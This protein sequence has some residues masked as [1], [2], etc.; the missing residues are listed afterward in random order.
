V[1]A[2]RV[3]EI[4]DRFVD[5]NS[6]V[7]PL[8]IEFVADETAVAAATL[9]YFARRSTHLRPTRPAQR[10][11]ILFQH[12]TRASAR[13]IAG[14][15]AL[16]QHEAT[17]L[18]HDPYSAT[19]AGAHGHLLAQEFCQVLPELQDMVSART[20]DI[21]DLVCDALRRS[22]RQF[23]FVGVGLDCRPFRLLG[24]QPDATVYEL[25]LPGMLEHREAALEL[26]GRLPQVTR[27][28][29][30]IDLE[31]QDVQTAICEAG[32]DERQPAVFVFEGASMYFSACTNRRILGSIARC[33][34][35]DNSELWFDAVAE[36]VVSHTS[37]FP[38]VEAFVRAISRI[39]EPFVFGLDDPSRLLSEM[40]IE[41]V[42]TTPA[43][44][45]APR[46]SSPVF[47]LYNFHVA[48]RS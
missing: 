32:F 44:A 31:Y 39:G 4:R 46:R 20:R 19:V 14:L 3:S 25:D 29:V 8:E 35:D 26:C 37:G 17:P 41:T 30:P 2:E 16:E 13:L 38:Q 48:R 27:R 22:I 24:D 7:V 15:R 18:F 23:V 42:R 5:G 33:M 10:P 40:G 45:Y 34:N 36:R 11:S 9:T 47:S 1:P 12:S 43:L 21:D 6:V 28:H